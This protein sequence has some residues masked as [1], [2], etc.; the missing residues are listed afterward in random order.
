[1][2]FSFRFINPNQKS[3][4]FGYIVSQNS[5]LAFVF[6][7]GDAGQNTDGDVLCPSLVLFFA[8]FAVFAVCDRVGWVWV[9][10]AQG[11]CGQCRMA[12][13]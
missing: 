8:V 6:P 3:A 7:P 5:L 4:L 2:Y 9:C 13:H 10:L 12:A 1:M 11:N